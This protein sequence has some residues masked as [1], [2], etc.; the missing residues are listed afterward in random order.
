M[1]V[2]VLASARNQTELFERWSALTPLHRSYR[3]IH[4]G[5]FGAPQPVPGGR[6]D[7]AGG[8]FV[9]GLFAGER[10]TFLDGASWQRAQPLG[11]SRV[12][13]DYDVSFD[14]NAASYL[15]ALAEGKANES[16]DK[17]RK[18]LEYLI[19]NRLNYDF[20][21]YNLENGDRIAHEGHVHPGI[22]ANLR[23]IEIAKDPDEQH[24][25]RTGELRPRVAA[26]IINQRVNETIHLERRVRQEGEAYSWLMDSFE[27]SYC[28]LLKVASLE[29]ELKRDQYERKLDELLV[30][31]DRELNALAVAELLIAEELFRRR[32]RLPFFGKIQ[33]GH[34]KLAHTLRNLAWDLQILRHFER[35]AAAL[36]QSG[37]SE[38]GLTR[39]YVPYLLTFDRRLAEVWDLLT[40]RSLLVP[41]TGL[42]WSAFTL[43]AGNNERA[44][45]LRQRL[46]ELSSTAATGDRRIRRVQQ[47][48]SERIAEL[49]A[50]LEVHL[51]IQARA[52]GNFRV[53]D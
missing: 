46:R 39:Y 13:L 1:I 51:R 49:T 35:R 11:A 42:G 22:R 48:G 40:L 47:D 8:A 19:A 45:Q 36:S 50:E 21:L 17:A 43:V 52:G 7:L 16:A 6:L 53:S 20:G 30:F 2:G 25:L 15:T 10:L 23:A 28:V 4:A 34:P 26:S 3:Y 32:E 33:K 27:L 14:T 9:R 37:S 31:M 24:F 44:P 12:A 41:P 29:L 38:G 18:V 5:D